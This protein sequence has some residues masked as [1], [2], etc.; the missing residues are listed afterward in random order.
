MATNGGIIG[1]SNKTSFGKCTVTTKTS[2]GDITTQ[3]GTRVIQTA[4][5]SIWWWRWSKLDVVVVVAAVPVVLSCK[6]IN[7]SGN[8]PYTATIG[9][10]GAGGTGPEGSGPGCAEGTTGSNSVFARNTSSGGGGGGSGEDNST[11]V[12]D[13]LVVL[14]VEVVVILVQVREDLELRCH[15]K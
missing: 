4:I 12:Q 6:E 13:K 11:N 7:V 10:G 1:K 5:T 15:R 14:V 2:S 3:P 8:T 9:G